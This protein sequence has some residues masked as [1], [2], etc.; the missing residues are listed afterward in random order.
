M[1]IFS[2]FFFSLWVIFD[3]ASSLG[4]SHVTERCRHTIHWRINVP[5]IPYTEI[6][7]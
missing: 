3:S 5:L 4:H 1:V 6:Q 7:F 2:F